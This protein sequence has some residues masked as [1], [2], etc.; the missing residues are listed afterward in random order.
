MFDSEWAETWNSPQAAAGEVGTY[1]WS[2]GDAGTLDVIRS[3][4]RARP[5]RPGIGGQNHWML[6][7][8]AEGTI[9]VMSYPAERKWLFE[10]D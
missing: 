10:N 5:L 4:F 3:D 7:E 6:A 2:Y 1:V 9:G 8:R